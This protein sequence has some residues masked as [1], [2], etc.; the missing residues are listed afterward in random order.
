MPA[1]LPAIF[2]H[3]WRVPLRTLWLAGEILLVAARYF[4]ECPPW[5]RS[6][7]AAAKA[8]WLHRSC[9]RTRRI[10]VAEVEPC[11]ELPASGLLVPSNGREFTPYLN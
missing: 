6:A 7:T 8:R 4:I 2:K 5:S 1:R 11:G 9:R 10:F 3:P